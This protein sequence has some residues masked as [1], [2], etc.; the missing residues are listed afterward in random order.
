MDWNVAFFMESL[1]IGRKP[2]DAGR[3]LETPFAIQVQNV[4]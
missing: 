1:A 2:L 4:E 3:R